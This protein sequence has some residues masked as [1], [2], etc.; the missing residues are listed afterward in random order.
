MGIELERLGL[1]AMYFIITAGR[2]FLNFCFSNT[3][4]I[5]VFS[6]TAHYDISLLSK[7]CMCKATAKHFLS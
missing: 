2:I 7:L 1:E 6:S 3:K 5:T 4:F